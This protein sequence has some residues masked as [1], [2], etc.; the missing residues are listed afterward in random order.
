MNP[1]YDLNAVAKNLLELTGKGWNEKVVGFICKAGRKASFMSVMPFANSLML[2]YRC[3]IIPRFVY[4]TSDAFH[5]SDLV[6]SEILSR[7]DELVNTII[8]WS[9]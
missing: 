6:D 7:I 9:S 8:E 3:H 2:D 5:G 4:V 1:S